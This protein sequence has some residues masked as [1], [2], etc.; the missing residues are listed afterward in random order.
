MNGAIFRPAT[1]DL[2][3][4]MDNKH[5]YYKELVQS[6]KRE[7][8]EPHVLSLPKGTIYGFTPDE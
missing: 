5:E 4:V 6:G 1:Y 8:A 7:P 2:Y 3:D